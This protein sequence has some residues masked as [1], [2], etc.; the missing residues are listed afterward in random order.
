MV[1]KPLILRDYA[2]KTNHMAAGVTD[3][4]LCFVAAE[5]AAILQSSGR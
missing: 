2:D 3:Q 1:F 4:A 5:A